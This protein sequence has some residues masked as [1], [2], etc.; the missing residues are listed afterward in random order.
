MQPVAVLV[1]EQQL[2]D[3]P[4]L[5]HVRRPPLRRDDGAEVEV[6]PEVVGE[7]LRPAVGLPLALDGEVLVVEQEDAAGPVSLGV[8]ERGDVD[9]VRPAVDRV[10]AAVAGLAGDLVG[11][12]HLHELGRARVVLDVD[13]VD[14]GAA[15]PGDEQV[16]AL[17]VRVRGP[18]AQRRGARVPAEVV[19]L[20]A[21]VR[22]VDAADELAVRGRA[23][24][25]VEHRDRVGLAVAVRA[26]VE[27]GDVGQRLLLR[28]G[29]LGGR[30]VE[31]GIGGPAR[32]RD[33]SWLGVPAILSDALGVWRTAYV[34][35]CAPPPAPWRSG[36]AAACKAVYTGSIPVGASSG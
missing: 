20:V 18:R 24:L 16:A 14:A 22:H 26:R 32:H 6:P 33:A 36:Y 4:V 13:H 28:S 11:L 27:G 29:R 9:P 12:D 30:G 19:E 8:A 25:D 35:R 17:D 5:D 10:R 23:L 31:A 21:G 15:Q 2:A 7:L 3:E 34:L 1:A